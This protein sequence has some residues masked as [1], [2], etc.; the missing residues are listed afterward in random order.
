[1]FDIEI[2]HDGMI[3]GMR[4]WPAPPREGEVVMVYDVEAGHDFGLVVTRVTYLST[5][6][7]QD[8]RCRVMVETRM[9][10]AME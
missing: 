3:W 6:R 1:M 4:T 7:S 9:K 5:S 10:G 2:M 8:G